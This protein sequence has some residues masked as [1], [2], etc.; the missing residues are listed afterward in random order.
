[1]RTSHFANADR[2]KIGDFRNG[3]AIGLLMFGSGRGFQSRFREKCAFAL[4]RSAVSFLHVPTSRRQWPLGSAGTA[5]PL[6][7]LLRVV[8]VLAVTSVKVT[9]ACP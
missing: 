1:L 2:R 9:T 8:Q 6:G 3:Q 7:G 4:T 5:V